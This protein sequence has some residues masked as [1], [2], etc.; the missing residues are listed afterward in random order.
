MTSPPPEAPDLRRVA[1]AALLGL[2][3][4]LATR[5]LEWLTPP[6]PPRHPVTFTAPDALTADDWHR[7]LTGL[8][9]RVRQ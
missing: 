1:D 4:A 8:R 6:T 7:V 2:T 9:H 5:D 3:P